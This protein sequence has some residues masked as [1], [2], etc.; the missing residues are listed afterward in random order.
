MNWDLQNDTYIYDGPGVD[1]ASDK[2]EYQEPSW[3]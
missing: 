2:N 3:G 1:S